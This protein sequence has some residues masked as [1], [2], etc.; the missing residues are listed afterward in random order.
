MILPSIQQSIASGIIQ[1]YDLIPEPR[2]ALLKKLSE[3]IKR[4]IAEE[5]PV[6]LLF[7]CTHNSRRSHMGQIW[8]QVASLHYGLDDV[9]CYS[10][11]TEETAF[12]PRSVKALQAAGLQVHKLSD[13]N[14][15]VYEVSY[16][17][18]AQTI[19]AFS[20]KY[21]HTSNPSGGFCAIMTCSEADEACP[22]IPGAELRISLPYR[23]PKE[24]D[25][26]PEE[27]KTYAERSLEI[28]REMFYAFSL[29]NS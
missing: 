13:G 24:S 29:V 5:E 16:A 8:A 2:R 14:N 7:V 19:Q 22:F 25:D 3:Y 12:N 18:E 20:K 23:D 26:S 28:A 4:K 6:R 15:P 21:D 10:G 17:H 1:S 9:A 11:G 27:E